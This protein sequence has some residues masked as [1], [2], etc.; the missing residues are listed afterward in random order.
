M[1]VSNYAI[2]YF[3]HKKKWNL[4][5][6][7]F[8]FTNNH[9]KKKIKL[10]KEERENTLNGDQPPLWCVR[11]TQDEMLLLCFVYKYKLVVQC[12]IKFTF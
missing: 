1:N 7:S 5:I 10:K 6:D 3:F 11:C 9:W 4:T 12:G 2:K 8:R